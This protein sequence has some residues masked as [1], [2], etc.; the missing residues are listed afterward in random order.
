MAAIAFGGEL[1]SKVVFDRKHQFYA[2]MPQ[3]YQLTQKRNP[4][5][6]RGV[7]HFFNRN[8]EAAQTLIKRMQIVQDTANQIKIDDVAYL[9]FN[10]AGMGM[11][12]IFTDND[13]EHPRDASLAAK[14]L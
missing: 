10:R 2:D 4:I 8:G 1:H 3:G 12:K 13:L 14:E 5:M 7:L 6:Q 9:D 11:L